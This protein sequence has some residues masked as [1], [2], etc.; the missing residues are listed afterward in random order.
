[1]IT[2]ETDK[3]LEM[4]EWSYMEA[5]LYKTNMGDFVRV[6]VTGTQVRALL[7]R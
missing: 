3:A 6:C 2:V 1:M 7:L 5:I 4:V